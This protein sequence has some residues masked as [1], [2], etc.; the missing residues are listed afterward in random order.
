MK[1]I[2]VAILGC[3]TVGTGVA[4]LLLENQ[5]VIQARTGCVLHLKYVADI[6]TQKDRGIPFAPG[7]MIADATLAVTDPDVQIVVETIGGEG[8]AKSLILDAISHGKHVVTANKA[9]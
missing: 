5:D 7:V 3:G 1:Q 4:R 2:N 8:I 9:L 6:D